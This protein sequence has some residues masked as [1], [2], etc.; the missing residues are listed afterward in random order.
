[1]RTTMTIDED[2]AIQIKKNKTKG[3]GKTFKEVVNDTLRDGLRFAAEAE[4]KPKEKFEL[5]GRLLRSKM[6]FDFNKVH[7][8]VEIIDE[9][10]ALK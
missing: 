9:E 4:R 10:S 7:Q 6:P 8:L 1:M 2:I 3:N 5:K